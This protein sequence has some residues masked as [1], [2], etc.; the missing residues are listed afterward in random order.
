MNENFGDKLIEQQEEKKTMMPLGLTPLKKKPASS[1]AK[2][3][4]T[5]S[6]A[7][8]LKS[9]ILEKVPKGSEFVTSYISEDFLS[10]GYSSSDLSGQM[11]ALRK[12][13]KIVNR[14]LEDEQDI[15]IYGKG[16]R[17]WKATDEFYEYMEN[18]VND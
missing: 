18:I 3:V 16:V 17:I 14:K 2:P 1:Q 4:N 11:Y 9:I 5:D 12:S 15:A 8:K 10:L 6:A 7:Y 13:G